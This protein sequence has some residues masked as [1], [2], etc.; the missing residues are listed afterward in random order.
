MLS[1]TPTCGRKNFTLTAHP[2]S[3]AN[4]QAIVGASAVEV[5]QNPTQAT[6]GLLEASHC[7]FLQIVLNPCT[8][9]ANLNTNSE[10]G[11]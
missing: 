8:S 4:P 7:H 5:L 2:G 3:S 11:G 1:K 9:S 6:L 10:M